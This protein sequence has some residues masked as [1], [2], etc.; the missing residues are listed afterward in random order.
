VKHWI[1]FEKRIEAPEVLEKTAKD[2]KKEDAEG[3]PGA[4]EM[5]RFRRSLS[6]G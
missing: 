1:G 2:W 4:I 5:V 6:Q 3:E